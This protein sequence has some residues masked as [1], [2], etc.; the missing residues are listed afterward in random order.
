MKLYY[1]KLWPRKA[2]FDLAISLRTEHNRNQRTWRRH[3]CLGCYWCCILARWHSPESGLWG[4]GAGWTHGQPT[5]DPIPTSHHKN[6]INGPNPYI[7]VL[8][9]IAE[10]LLGSGFGVG[11]TELVSMSLEF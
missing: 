7:M 4:P 3:N 2:P 1:H 6:I 11:T 8:D 5:A 9:F 10:H